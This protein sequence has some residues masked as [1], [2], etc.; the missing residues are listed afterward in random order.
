MNNE[1]AHY[2]I[3]GMKWGIRKKHPKKNIHPDYAR[4]HSKKPVWE[5]SDAE[6]QSVNNRLN[7][8]RNYKQLTKK[9][10]IGQKMVEDISKEMAKDFLK[11]NI[12]KHAIPFLTKVVKSSIETLSEKS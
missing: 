5:M 12:N 8:E 2:G 9:K 6:I 1:L 11:K 10:V 4:A 3:L 7:L